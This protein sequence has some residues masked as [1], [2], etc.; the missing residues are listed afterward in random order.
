MIVVGGLLQRSE[1][2]GS[3][4]EVHLHGVDVQTLLVEERK[5]DV[6]LALFVTII[7]LLVPSQGI[8]AEPIRNGGFKNRGRRG[9]Q[10]VINLPSTIMGTSVVPRRTRRRDASI[11]KE[12]S[13]TAPIINRAEEAFSAHTHTSLERLRRSGGARKRMMSRTQSSSIRHPSI[14]GPAVGPKPTYTVPVDTRTRMGHRAQCLLIAVALYD[15]KQEAYRTR[16][17]LNQLERKTFNTLMGDPGNNA[18]VSV[19]KVARAERKAA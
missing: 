10:W 2:T 8:N 12:Q 4:T 18:L 14:V 3:V 17:V 16:T 13:V 5:G 9:L 19:Y 7:G 15:N 11:S 1:P 6:M